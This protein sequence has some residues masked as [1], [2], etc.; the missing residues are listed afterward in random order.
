MEQEWDKSEN[1]QEQLSDDLN[2]V[3]PSVNY[4]E[5]VA[6]Y[7]YAPYFMLDYFVLRNS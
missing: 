1:T 7:T 4:P 5:T 3:D 2:D 6:S